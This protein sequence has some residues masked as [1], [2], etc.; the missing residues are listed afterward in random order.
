MEGQKKSGCTEEKQGCVEQQQSRAS[1]DPGYVCVRPS[2][3]V[4]TSTAGSQL[5]V[6]TEG[7]VFAGCCVGYLLFNPV[8]RATGRVPVASWTL[9]GTKTLST[10]L[11]EVQETEGYPCGGS[12]SEGPGRDGARA[13]NT[14]GAQSLVPG[15]RIG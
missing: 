5:R 11:C 6:R 1:L 7:C 3:H 4:A 15:Q 13:V 8:Y 2:T 9:R 10:E 14:A 12:L